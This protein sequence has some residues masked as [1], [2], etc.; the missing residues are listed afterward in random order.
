M[1]AMI[2]AAGF[3]SRLKPITNN[4]PKALVK[5]RGKTLLEYAIEKL[6]HYSVDEIIVNVHHF[7]Q[8]IKDFISSHDFGIPIY[9]SDETSLLRNTGGGLVH[10]QQYLQGDSP[11][12]VYNVDIISTINLH[13]LL[14][15]HMKHDA[16]ITLAVKERETSR[17][18]LFDDNMELSAWENRVT[19]EHKIAKFSDNY[20][21]F[22]FSG[23]QIVNP[24]I[25][26]L[27]NE[28][29]CFS[30][31]DLYLRLAQ[32]NSIKAYNHTEDFWLDVG[33]F[34]EIKS[35]EKQLA[36]QDLEFTQ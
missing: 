27:I 12:F 2:F 8:Q 35:V 32:H 3:G 29:G 18:L 9:I 4:I 16:L 7:S 22:A 20:I 5:F 23:I 31:M 34:N 28:T 19:N 10:A 1:K 11:F 13:D 21:P 30:I 6:K 14:E 26:E 25:F 24:E 15:F 36:T 33:K 17:Y